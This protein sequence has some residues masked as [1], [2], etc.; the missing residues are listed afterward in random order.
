MQIE[1]R[2]YQQEA[3]N[4]LL[5]DIQ[6]GYNP[7][8]AVP[9]GAGKTIIMALV[10]YRYLQLNPSHNIL[11]VSTT[12]SILEQD[13]A[14]LQTFFPQSPIGLFSAG[15]KSKTLKQVTVAGIQ[16]IWRNPQHFKGIFQ[17]IIIDECHQV[18]YK[19]KSMYRLFLSFME[20]ATIAGVSGTI[21][22]R[23]QG[24]IHKGDNAIFNKLSYD[25]THTENFNQLIT[26]GYLCNLVSK[27]THMEL[28][29]SK[30]KQR[31]DDF[32]QID[33]AEQCD[34]LSI[35]KEAVTE[36]L[37]IG[38]IYKSWLIFAI[39]IE[40]AE[41]ITKELRSKGIN[42]YC[43]HSKISPEQQDTIKTFFRL[44]KIQCVVSVQMVTTGFDVPH[45]DLI[46]LLRPTISPVLHVQMIG[47]GSRVSEDKTHCLVLDFAGNIKRLGPINDVNIPK[48]RKKT[49]T[50]KLMVRTCP[51]CMIMH[52]I[53]IKICPICGFVFPVK[54][55]IKDT[56]DSKD[57]IKRKVEK[58]KT[59]I[60]PDIYQVDVQRIQYSIHKKKN[61][62]DSFRV[63]YTCRRPDSALSET[64]NEYVCLDH[65]GW[66]AKTARS[67]IRRRLFNVPFPKNVPELYECRNLLKSAVK[68]SIEKNQ[69]TQVLGV[70]FE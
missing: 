3:A 51:I 44:G 38:H 59:V 33:L 64:I 32:N 40:H 66:P 63:A 65:G 67:W 39:N 15:L 21:F 19:A 52:H 16:S 70:T 62:P 35:T 17:L 7:I 14:I 4:R 8:I 27:S 60:P 26:D 25:L 41:N 54:E 45:I 49:K 31:T 10:I 69:F 68:L 23:G 56:P 57:V 12:S 46:I 53:S 28:D 61:K 5:E 43:L 34:R 2:P 13:R 24:F 20:T 58:V 29:T 48:K 22:R 30:V 42:A 11:L 50:K 6:N 55:K 9:T 37:K 36:I 18:P 47:R 1:H